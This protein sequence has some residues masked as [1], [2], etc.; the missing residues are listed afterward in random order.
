MAIIVHMLLMNRERGR[1]SW[2][3][4]RD[5]QQI[6]T[7]LAFLFAW[8]QFTF[9]PEDEDA[10]DLEDATLNDDWRQLLNYMFRRSAPRWRR[11]DSLAG[12]SR[13]F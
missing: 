7:V 3:I 11:D 12:G 9:A 5:N 13:Y 4:I 2:Q 8:T 10:F 1:R 6:V